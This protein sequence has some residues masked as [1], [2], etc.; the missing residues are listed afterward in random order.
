MQVH[1]SND[2]RIIVTMTTWSKRIGN[3]PAVLTNILNNTMLPYKIVI[4]LAEEEFKNKEKDFSNDV[5]DFLNNHKDIIEVHWVKHNTKVWKKS[6]PTLLRYPNDL[7]I[8][9]DDDFIY[10]T[11]FVKTFF[12]K[13]NNIPNK[14]LTGTIA[15]INAGKN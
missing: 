6:I 12:D 14:P 10:P 7:I 1:Y 3:I 9:I 2:E 4:N 5:N 15:K 13:H 8:C 11:D